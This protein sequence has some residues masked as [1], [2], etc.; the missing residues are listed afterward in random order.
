M[1]WSGRLTMACEADEAASAS[2]TLEVSIH[3]MKDLPAALKFGQGYAGNTPGMA[4]GV[5]SRLR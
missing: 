5:E 4:T 3:R 1:L 2:P